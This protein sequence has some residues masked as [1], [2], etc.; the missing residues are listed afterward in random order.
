MHPAD[1]LVHLP[2][3]RHFLWPSAPHWAQQCPGPANGPRETR[4]IVT[5]SS[6]LERKQLQEEEPALPNAHTCS[7]VSHTTR[8][9]LGAAT[10]HGSPRG[11]LSIP[12]PIRSLQGEVWLSPGGLC[13]AVGSAG[14]SCPGC[15]E[16]GAFGAVLDAHWCG[17]GQRVRARGVR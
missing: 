9:S 4:C 12:V 2:W 13:V 11:R 1:C 8:S 6:E 15:S 14:M 17:D 7:T 16:V 10:A 3:E 5:A